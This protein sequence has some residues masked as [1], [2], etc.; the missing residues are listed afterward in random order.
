MYF[1]IEENCT[2]HFT[3]IHKTHRVAEV[4]LMT[5]ANESDCRL[6]WNCESCGNVIRAFQDDRISTF[7]E[8]FSKYEP[9]R[10]NVCNDRAPK[11]ITS[12]QHGSLSR[13]RT[14]D[15]IVKLVIAI[16]LRFIYECKTCLGYLAKLLRTPPNGLLPCKNATFTSRMTDDIIDKIRA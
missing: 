5:R 14:D 7:M 1:D 16:F 3:I 12:L 13:C 11:R 15:C 6:N 2:R 4:A 9:W 10:S 8:R